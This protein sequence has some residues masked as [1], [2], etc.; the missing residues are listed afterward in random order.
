MANEFVARN[1]FISLN[2]S[3]ITGSLGVSNGANV[4]GDT[5]ITGSLVVSGSN[6]AGVFSQG[7]TLSDYV[8][9]I[10]TEAAYMVWRAPFS[11]SVVGLYG[12]REGGGSAQVNALRSG[13]SGFGLHSN[14]NIT[15]SSENIWTGAATLQNQNYNIGDSLKIV[16]SGSANNQIAVQ[17]D[18]IK[19]F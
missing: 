17:V 9:G 18:F 8:S 7:G 10:S 6:G 3:Q 2:D 1:G 5:T 16:V 15:L 11:C 12:W 4:K 19:K 13:S 14:T